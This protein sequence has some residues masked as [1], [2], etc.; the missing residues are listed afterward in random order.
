MYLTGKTSRNLIAV[1]A[2]ALTIAGCKKETAEKIPDAS[3]GPSTITTNIYSDAASVSFDAA[4]A[5]RIDGF[6]A[7]AP[8]G[9]GSKMYY[10]TGKTDEAGATNAVITFSEFSPVTDQSQQVGTNVSSIRFTGTKEQVIHIR[11]DDQ[12]S[13]DF[14]VKPLTYFSIAFPNGFQKII[15]AWQEDRQLAIDGIK[16]MVTQA[17]GLRVKAE[18][19]VIQ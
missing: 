7:L 13:A 4:S 9:Q 12:Q 10:I 5:A 16:S 18:K 19:P 3:A 1:I 14:T 8:V 2:C 15:A 11:W 17:N 6:T